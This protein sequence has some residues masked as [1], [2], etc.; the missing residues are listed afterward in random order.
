MA[1]FVFDHCCTENVDQP[2][3]GDHNCLANI[4]SIVVTLC[5]ELWIFLIDFNTLRCAMF[6]CHFDFF[7]TS[8]NWCY[9]S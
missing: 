2:Y 9:R 6:I 8:H 3:V 1:N 4:V 7:L 5:S